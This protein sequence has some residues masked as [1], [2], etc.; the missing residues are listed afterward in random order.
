MPFKIVFHSVQAQLEAETV[1]KHSYMYEPNFIT[2]SSGC[3]C[4][5]RSLCACVALQTI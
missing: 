3:E 2:V 4:N 5:E 1:E